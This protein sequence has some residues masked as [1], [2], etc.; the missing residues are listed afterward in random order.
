MKNPK[1]IL[2]LYC[3]RVGLKYDD[4]ITSWKPGQVEA[5]KL[6][7][8]WHDAVINSSGFRINNDTQREIDE[9][10]KK[11]KE[12]QENVLPKEV[13]DEIKKAFVIYDKLYQQRLYSV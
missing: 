3:N 10:E 4:S 6:W 1:K 8:G 5:F 12:F 7:D 2:K 9:K 13:Q 11:L